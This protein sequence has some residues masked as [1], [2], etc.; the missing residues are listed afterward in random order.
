M[1]RTVVISA[2]RLIDV[3]QVRKVNEPSV[4][5]FTICF[6]SLCG[7]ICI[8]TDWEINRNVIFSRRLNVSLCVRQC[9]AWNHWGGLCLQRTRSCLFEAFKT[10]SRR[11][12]QL[13][14]ISSAVGGILCCHCPFQRMPV[15]RTVND[16]FPLYLRCAL[17]PGSGPFNMRIS[18]ANKTTIVSLFKHRV[19]W[20]STAC[21]RMDE[22]QK[23][24]KWS[25]IRQIASLLF[26]NL[27]STVP[28]KIHPHVDG[29]FY[30]A[31]VSMAFLKWVDR[32]ETQ[33]TATHT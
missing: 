33:V 22:R 4:I 2:L 7:F 10:Y 19:S 29:I 18:S 11:N 26:T 13:E 17:Q 14:S 6:C 28:I 8:Q 9:H 30:P 1:G 27:R 31:T 5:Q 21:E 32:E 16:D 25:N 20:D 3:A 24:N 12:S 23:T 15:A